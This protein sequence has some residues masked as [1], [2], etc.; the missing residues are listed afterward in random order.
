VASASTAHA[1]ALAIAAVWFGVMAVTLL[2]PLSNDR[3]LLYDPATFSDSLG[4]GD[5]ELNAWILA[6]GTHKLSSGD[7]SGF[8]DANICYPSRSTLA[9]SE[10]MI[11]VLPFF[12][13]IYLATG[14]LALSL[15]LWTVLTFVLSGLAM[16]AVA[17]RW[18]GCH[19]AAL[20][21]GSMYA[22]APWRFRELLHVQL[23]TVPYLPLIAYVVWSARRRGGRSWTVLVGSLA[24]QALSSFYLGYQGFVLALLVA[25]AAVVGRT[26]GR[27][28]YA[29]FVAT[30][31]LAAAALMLPFSWPYLELSHIDTR[32]VVP[33]DALWTLWRFLFPVPAATSGSISW[34]LWQLVP[35]LAIGAAVLAWRR[36]SLRPEIGCFA[37]IVL[38]AGWLGLG[39]SASLGGVR[40]GA[41][42]DLAS[43]IVPG[44]SAVRV[45]QRFGIL[46]WLALCLTVAASVTALAASTTRRWM[47]VAPCVIALT[48]ASA[49]LRIQT[50]TAPDV[51]V[52]LSPYDWLAEHGGGDPLLELPISRQRDADSMYRSTHHWLPLVVGATGHS[53]PQYWMVNSIA[54]ALPDPRAASTLIDLRLARWL[55]VHLDVSE[56]PILEWS[57]LA[58]VGARERLRSD[59]FVLYELPFDGSLA[60][61]VAAPSPARH[62]TLLGVPRDA[63]DTSDLAGRIVPLRR[64]VVSSTW[65]RR[66]AVPLRI[67]ND[68][69][70]PWPGVA[71]GEDGLVG[72]VFQARPQ[73]G[74]QTVELDT[75]H[76]LPADLRPGEQTTIRPLLRPRGAP[77]LYQLIPCLAQAGRPLRRCFESASVSFRV[78]GP[79]G[80]ARQPRQPAP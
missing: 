79:R 31:L 38:A 69:R 11:G 1:A 76:R 71:L 18:F 43:A 17:L 72:V 60:S 2:A 47:I 27:W 28:R 36:S 16:Y 37:L 55:L 70:V 13:P 50:R 25:V 51:G 22:F 21:A 57:Q 62:R 42:H 63:L 48:L 35:A 61:P 45:P 58:G 54:R 12:A 14:D 26:D 40:I 23:L 9:F 77:G 4:Y 44:W 73:R 49:S 64:R 39:P 66:A 3:E 10:H 34:G 53:P 5:V 19:A 52:D 24:L 33:P 65:D 67:R 41:I 74:G 20:L 7:P 15:N 80:S 6:W 68:A 46:I 29:A 32:Q 59:A 56:V 78:V 30:A 75:F 8:F